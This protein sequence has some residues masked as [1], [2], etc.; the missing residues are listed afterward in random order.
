MMSDLL[1]HVDD[2][3]RLRRAL[4][5]RLVFPGQVLPQFVTYLEA[6]GATTIS[7]ELAIA[8]AALPAGVQPISLAHRLGAVRGFARYL[9]TIEPTTEVPPCG[10]WPSV[11]RRP[12]PYLWSDAE[13][14]ALILAARGLQPP[15]QAVVHET[16][17]GLLAV[18][19]MR[20]GEALALT[21]PD[22]DLA[23]GVI[24]IREAKFGRV[25]LVPLHSSAT[26]ALRSYA[27]RLEQLCPKP[28]SQMFFISGAGTALTYRSVR[29]TFVELTTA[30]GLRTT[31]VRPRIH[32]LRHSFAVRT[33]LTWERDG[34]DVADRMVVLSNYLGHVNPSGTYWYLSAS[35]ELME[36]AAARLSNRYGERS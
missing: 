27:A 11:A 29:A 1:R 31:S 20:V 5:F 28:R 21:R 35:P 7:V 30:L 32:D 36:L 25:R 16:L 13:V 15:Q 9:A 12:A 6:A 4:G 2:Y 17:L 19:G 8:W 3:L 24:T 14:R 33:L 23:D 18:T 26:N 22:V 34:V 10:I